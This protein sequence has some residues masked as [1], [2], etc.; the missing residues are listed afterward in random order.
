MTPTAPTH[1][2]ALE[3]GMTITFENTCVPFFAARRNCIGIITAVEDGRNHRYYTIEYAGFNLPRRITEAQITGFVHPSVM[4]VEQEADTPAAPVV[5]P[6]AREQYDLAWSVVR[7]KRASMQTHHLV[8]N[9]V[10]PEIYHAAQVAQVTRNHTMRRLNVA[11]LNKAEVAMGRPAM[12]ELARGSAH[13]N[14][15]LSGKLPS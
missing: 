5:T 4:E 11:W 13:N 15:A 10:T 1:T 9:A 12:L 8:R 3:V 6:N 7:N 14:F 2:P